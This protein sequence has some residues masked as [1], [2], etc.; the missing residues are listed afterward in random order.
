[1]QYRSDALGLPITEVLLHVLRAVCL[2]FDKGRF[3]TNVFLLLSD[4]GHVF[5]HDFWADLH[6]S[7]SVVVKRVRV[8]FPD[9]NTVRHK[10]AHGRLVIV[11]THHA[12]GDA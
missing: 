4:A 7:H 2:A 1:M 11:I 9:I 8:G 12:A 10:L 5:V 3:I 6:V